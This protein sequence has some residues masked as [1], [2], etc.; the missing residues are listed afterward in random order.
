VELRID[1]LR[2]GQLVVGVALLG[3][4]L[5]AD[6]GGADAGEESVGLELGIGLTLAIDDGLEIVEQTGQVFFH[7]PT[8][9]SGEGI[10]A[11]PAA[12]QLVHP[13]AEGDPAPAEMFL[14][15]TLSA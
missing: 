14:G 2:G 4:Q 12:D 11:S 6:L 13:L 3:D 8:P 7:G 1:R 10:E 5:L 9:P 15:P